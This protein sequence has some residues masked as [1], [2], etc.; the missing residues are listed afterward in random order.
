MTL[1]TVLAFALTLTL[2]A[3]SPGPGVVAIIA[4]SIGRGFVAGAATTAGIVIGDLIFF[5][6]AI[7]GLTL[8]AQAMGELFLIVKFAGAAYLIYLGVKLWR[9][10]VVAISV[11]VPAATRRGIARDALAGLALTLGNPKTI[12][13]YLGV[14]PSVVAIDQLV[15][16]DVAVLTV[17]DVAVVGGVLLAYAG[18]AAR[19]RLS[20]TKPARLRVLNRSAGTAMIGA[21]VAVAAR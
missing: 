13:F 6:F 9:A 3:A 5:C 7:F 15:L 12:A 18:F 11:D 19:A 10:P 4:A 8:V 1:T 16:R 14:L 2:A 20:F 21:G 17:V